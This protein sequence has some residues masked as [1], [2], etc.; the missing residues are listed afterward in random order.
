MASASAAEFSIGM[1]HD[2][3]L[4]GSHRSKETNCGQLHCTW[5]KG[6]NVLVPQGDSSGCS[7]PWPWDIA[8]AISEL[9][10]LAV[11]V[12]NRFGL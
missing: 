6:T 2:M 9:L 11:L 5:S 10:H 1:K 8:A 4:L 12:A 7:G 3:G